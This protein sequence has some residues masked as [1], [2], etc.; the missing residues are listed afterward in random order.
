MR[1]GYAVVTNEFWRVSG[2]TLKRIFFSC[3]FEVLWYL[4]NF[5]GQPASMGWLSDM[6]YSHQMALS[7]EYHGTHDFLVGN[8]WSGSPHRSLSLPQLESDTSYTHTQISLIGTSLRVSPYSKGLRLFLCFGKVEKTR[9]EWVLAISTSWVELC[10]IS[11]II[12]SF[13]KF[14][15]W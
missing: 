13:L 7:L 5:P 8:Y 11:V 3:L 2:L 12:E 10:H 1:V 14:W 9:Y 4:G 6:M 15:T